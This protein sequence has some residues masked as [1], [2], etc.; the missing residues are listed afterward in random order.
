MYLKKV[1]DTEENNMRIQYANDFV[2]KLG[3]GDPTKCVY[4]F[5][6]D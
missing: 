4:Q 3:M 2:N 6:Y 1:Y 5:I